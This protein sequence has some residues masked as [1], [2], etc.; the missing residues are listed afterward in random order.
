M[1]DKREQGG[2]VLWRSDARDVIPQTHLVF[3]DLADVFWEN[4]RRPSFWAIWGSLPGL[5]FDAASSDLRNVPGEYLFVLETYFGGCAPKPRY[6]GFERRPAACINCLM[7]SGDSSSFA[8]AAVCMALVG[9][10]STK[11]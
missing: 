4:Y 5:G 1:T 8:A 9:L 11:L 10:S 3:N 6:P 7:A 2:L